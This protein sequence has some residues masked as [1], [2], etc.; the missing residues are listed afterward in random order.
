M[1]RHG[2]R[3]EGAGRKPGSASAASQA[4]REL[5]QSHCE[6]AFETLTSIMGDTESPNLFHLYNPVCALWITDHCYIVT[7][8]A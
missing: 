1:T 3:R 7:N 4:I 2:G 8:A 5:A 6:Q